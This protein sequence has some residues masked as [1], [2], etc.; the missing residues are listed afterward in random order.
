[1][2]VVLL[3]Q[4]SCDDDYRLKLREKGTRVRLHCDIF[5]IYLICSKN[6]NP[7]PVA[8]FLTQLKLLSCLMLIYALVSTH[9]LARYPTQCSNHD[10][11]HWWIAIYEYNAVLYHS[12]IEIEVKAMSKSMHCSLWW[13]SNYNLIW[14][15]HVFFLFGNGYV[16]CIELIHK[17]FITEDIIVKVVNFDVVTVAMNALLFNFDILHFCSFQFAVQHPSFSH[18]QRVYKQRKVDKSCLNFR[19]LTEQLRRLAS[20]SK[21]VDK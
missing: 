21:W 10:K 18:F 15:I 4:Y 5:N 17:P 14:L 9:F 20:K 11:M 16:S 19:N 7:S 12:N 3:I 2:L 6:S 1:M 8:Y 13:I